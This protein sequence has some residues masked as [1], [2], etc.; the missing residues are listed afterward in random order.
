MEEESERLVG[1]MAQTIGP[2]VW[3]GIV[4]ACIRHGFVD[5]DEL[6][7]AE[8]IDAALLGFMDQTDSTAATVDGEVQWSDDDVHIVVDHLDA[9]L[10]KAAEAMQANEHW[11]A[12]LF[13]ATWL[14][15]WVNQVLMS[16]CVRS[17]VPEG[18]AVAL[19]RS[20]SFNLKLKDVWKSLGAEPI[21]REYLRIMNDLMEFRNGFVHYKW[22]AR[23]FSD[24]DAYD[25]RVEEVAVSAQGLVPILGDLEDQLLFS[26]RRKALRARL[27]LTE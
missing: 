2:S 6:T 4:D 20:C 11:F 12:I 3:W 16:L 13:Y 23:T 8:V 15:H 14:E 19:V 10:Q 25:R 1:E 22:Q 17:G 24:K 5:L 26:G 9:L 21:E 7:D 27:G 18:V